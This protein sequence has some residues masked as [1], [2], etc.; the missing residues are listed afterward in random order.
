MCGVCRSRRFSGEKRL[1][2]SA[3]HTT[4]SV[5]LLQWQGAVLRLAR[6]KG[7]IP[8]QFNQI[9][10]SV[11]TRIPAASM[12]RPVTGVRKRAGSRPMRLPAS[13]AFLRSLSQ[14]RPAPLPAMALQ[15]ECRV[16]QGNVRK[17][18]REISYLALL[19]DVVLFGEQ[20]DVVAQFQ[21]AVKEL[22]RVGLPSSTLPVS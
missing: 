6:I 17:G 11:A 8:I 12:P 15:A 19:L 14:T 22:S 5:L 3:P 4:L 16:D 18:L 2:G 1:P 9:G 7:D 21:E 13:A 10:E 20:S